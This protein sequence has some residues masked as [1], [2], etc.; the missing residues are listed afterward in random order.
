M[1]RL[2]SYHIVSISRSS[3][4]TQH[5]AKTFEELQYNVQS[6]LIDS[7]GAMYQVTSRQL[8]NLD[9]LTEALV[10]ND[11][12]I[13][14]IAIPVIKNYLSNGAGLALTVALK[15]TDAGN[16]D[17]WVEEVTARLF[18]INMTEEQYLK[19]ESVI[20]RLNG[21]KTVA[22]ASILYTDTGQ[23]T[24]LKSNNII[25]LEDRFSSRLRAN[26][27][28][29]EP[30]VIDTILS[31]KK[32][33]KSYHN[34]VDLLGLYV[35]N[36]VGLNGKHLNYSGVPNKLNDR[37]AS[38][39]QEFRNTYPYKRKEF[40]QLVEFLVLDLGFTLGLNGLFKALTNQELAQE[41]ILLQEEKYLINLT[42]FVLKHCKNYAVG[43]LTRNYYLNFVYANLD[44]SSITNEQIKL[45]LEA[46]DQHS[47]P[48]KIP[49]AVK[50]DIDKIFNLLQKSLSLVKKKKLSLSDYKEDVQVI[51]RKLSSNNI[52][53]AF[54]S[55]QIITLYNLVMSLKDSELISQFFLELGPL[56]IKKYKQEDSIIEL[57]N[58]FSQPGYGFLLKELIANLPDVLELQF[59]SSGISLVG[60]YNSF[61][62]I[63]N[64]NLL[65]MFSSIFP[66]LLEKHSTDMRSIVDLYNAII[67]N[68]GITANQN[69]ALVWSFLINFSSILKQ[70]FADGS[71]NKINNLALLFTHTLINDLIEKELLTLDELRTFL[72]N[73]NIQSQQEIIKII[74]ELEKVILPKQPI[75][76]NQ[77]SN[78]TFK[79][80]ALEVEFNSTNTFNYLVANFLASHLCYLDEIYINQQAS[81]FR[82]TMEKAFPSLKK[83]EHYQYIYNFEKNTFLVLT[84][85]KNGFFTTSKL[86]FDKIKLCKFVLEPIG[87][88]EQLAICE[89]NLQ[90]FP[91]W[92]IDG[93][94]NA[95]QQESPEEL[96]LLTTSSKSKAASL[97]KIK[98]TIPKP[99][100][101]FTQS[102]SVLH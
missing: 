70:K 99:D 30:Q 43:Q 31:L 3:S 40:H 11:E 72:F 39:A 86:D 88:I 28:N 96:P 52:L 45:A 77:T 78:L 83:A 21:I 58:G 84:E 60:T 27:S 4:H 12:N 51:F 85:G 47:L 20:P 13:F 1:N 75:Y 8:I 54:N 19:Y 42:T 50:L 22:Q 59:K 36:L 10:K 65:R 7:L 73:S 55:K 76:I 102:R 95:Y 14:E 34:V 37:D 64:E 71:I 80:A 17:S 15:S 25:S 56:I 91:R 57:Y 68:K 44:S 81:H 46:E 26:N 94:R 63:N 23:L 32:F 53:K 48:L 98:E 5:Y 9:I 2:N 16:I 35:T 97:D 62:L 38:S 49:F 82:N 101:S 93:Y 33:F 74:A 69:I 24:K 79:N 61:I 29:I 67:G 6:T 100:G 89:E 18:F 41:E 92:I 87:N 66:E 90:G